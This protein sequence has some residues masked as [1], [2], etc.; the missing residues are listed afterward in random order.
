MPR[1]GSTK[2]YIRALLFGLL[3]ELP[4]TA[5]ACIIDLSERS[6]VRFPTR[7]S[8]GFYNRRRTGLGG[9]FAAGYH[10]TGKAIECSGANLLGAI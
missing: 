3:D 6:W 1:N 5:G 4:S 8:F 7:A 2:F 10:P 9:R